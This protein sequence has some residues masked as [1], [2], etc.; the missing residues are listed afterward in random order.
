LFALLIIYNRNS[1]TNYAEGT[2]PGSIPPHTDPNA[3]KVI[4]A[5]AT[6]GMSLPDAKDK[7]KSVL[8]SHFVDSDWCP[9]LKIVMEA[10]DD[11][12]AT[13]AAVSKLKSQAQQTRT[14]PSPAPMTIPQLHHLE[15]SLMSSVPEL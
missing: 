12:V 10:E 3:W 4:D 13:L 8:G 14:S 15:E 9:A 1:T 11:T 7:L 6:S 5:F 2:I